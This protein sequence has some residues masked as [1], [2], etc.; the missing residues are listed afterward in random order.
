MT[1]NPNPNGPTDQGTKDGDPAKD[2]QGNPNPN[3]PDASKDGD[4]AKDGQDGKGKDAV[5][6]MDAGAD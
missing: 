4:P 6:A 3:G 5:E 1:T 2:G